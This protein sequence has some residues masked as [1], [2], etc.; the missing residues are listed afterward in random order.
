MT[1][2][3]YGIPTCNTCKKALR[4]LDDRGIPYDFIN[5]RQQPP[6]ET[7]IRTWVNTLGSKPLRNTSGQVYRSL[8]AERDQWD[9]DRWIAEFS[10][11]PMLLKRPLWVTGDRAVAV[12]FRDE[13]AIMAAIT[14]A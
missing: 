14:S 3:I 6:S 11:E 9:D 7:D 12:G 1:L 8:G 5:T 4:W 10:R 13:A 2:K